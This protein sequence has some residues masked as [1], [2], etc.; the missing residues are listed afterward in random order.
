MTKF[1]DRPIGQKLV[2][3]T[4]ATTAVA[5]L[6][7]G[8]GIVLADAILFRG[9][10]QRDLSALTRI[11][12]DNSTGALAFEDPGSAAQTLGALRARP[13]VNGACI[14]RSDGSMLAQYARDQGFRCPP[15]DREQAIHFSGVNLVGSQP[16][17]LNGRR[18]G[19]LMLEYGLGE[20][21]ERIR[22]YGTTVLAVLL[23]ASFLAFLLASRLRS[24][25]TTPVSRLVDATTSVSETGDY[26]VR[27]EKLSGDEL[28]VLV[29]RFNEMLAGIQSRDNDLKNALGDL[30][31]ALQEVEQ[32]RR[33]F[34]FMAE[35]MPQKIFTASPTGDSMYLNQLWMDFTGLQYERIRDWGWTQFIHPDDL[36]SSVRDWKQA[37]D[38]GEPL[39]ITNR[40]R[41]ADGIY[42]WHLSRARAMRD[43]SGDIVLWVGSS[44]EIHEQKEIEEE[45]RRANEDLQQF[46]YSASH[47]LQEPIRNVAVYSEVIARR[48]EN[49]VDDEGRQFLG[50]LREGGRRLA[51]L[52]NDLLAYTRASMAELGE[53]ELDAALALENALASLAQAV[54]ETGAVVT[55]DALP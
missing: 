26:G 27:V 38:T 33:R 13:Y 29:D 2:I 3:I 14:Y 15:P 9:Y 8:A 22:L 6:L 23:A 5:M 35:S 47:D 43:A 25:I 34:S 28:G 21:A 20:V 49:L 24:V 10:L 39:Q 4:M 52:V 36:E 53:A 12:A 42:R 54:R 50:F 16:I 44:T 55:R 46:A 41:R 17:L 51:T 48:Y 11:V 37:I 18:I 1:R 45:L 19:T 31:A 40:F 30:E 32:E 7:A